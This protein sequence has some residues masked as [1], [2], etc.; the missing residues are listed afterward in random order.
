MAER[1]QT[2]D[3]FLQASVARQSDDD[4]LAPVI[5]ASDLSAALPEDELDRVA[6]TLLLVPSF[7]AEF[8]RRVRHAAWVV[9]SGQNRAVPP[10]Y[11]DAVAVVS[12]GVQLLLRAGMPKPDVRSFVEC[13][14]CTCTDCH[15]EQCDLLGGERFDKIARELANENPG[16]SSQ[17]ARGMADERN[18]LVG[19][20][21]VESALPF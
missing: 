10:G 4:V 8:F 2:R 3:F 20:P 19:G 1:V 13:V 18:T 12:H 7:R 5:G 14:L 16:T 6:P 17:D 21:N 9:R 11:D 15:I